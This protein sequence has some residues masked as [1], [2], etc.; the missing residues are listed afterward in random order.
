MADPSSYAE[1][2][3]ERRHDRTLSS[4]EVVLGELL[5]WGDFRSVVDVGCGVG[6][7][8]AAA[9]S[10][11]IADVFGLEGPW[12]AIDR[13]VISRERFRHWNLEQPIRLPREFD[14]AI[15][16]EVAEHLRPESADQF[17]D[18]LVRLAPVVLFSAAIPWQRGVHHVNEQWPDYWVE[19]FE[20]QGYL[21]ADPI[22]SMVWRDVRV[23]PWYAQNVLVFV[24]ESE[25]G[26]W[27]RLADAARAVDRQR[28]AVVHPG[29]YLRNSDPGNLTL[30]ELLSVLPHAVLRAV[31]R[32]V[33]SQRRKRDE[34]RG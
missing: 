23:R 28:L 5:R 2:F 17:V 24:R 33:G 12:L 9:E 20:R 7:W 3:Y 10:L 27:P 26:R 31:R 21:L 14:L 34:A 29:L 22:R 13:L 16:L 25:S 18:T 8:L 15:S 11:G 30:R 32:R 6:T 1:A 19:R 4:A